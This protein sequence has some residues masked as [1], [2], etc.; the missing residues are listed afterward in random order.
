MK[1]LD[2]YNKMRTEIAS[3]EAVMEHAV[4]SEHATLTE[5]SMH[6]LKAGGKRIRPIFVLLSGKFGKGDQSRLI[7]VAA[8]LE[9]IH[10][11]SLVHDDVI[12]DA[13]TR[14]GKPTVKAKWDNRVAMYTGD[15]IF[16]KAL[17]LA[18]Q[19]PNPKIH[20]ILSRA[21]VQM[22][23]GEMEQIRLFYEPGQSIRDY[24]LRIRRKTALLI[25]VSCQI[26]A[27]AD[28]KSVV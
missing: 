12:D 28:R 11:A 2:I 16:A 25:A 19:I 22:S 26:G 17:K 1:L 23:I 7:Q 24:L 3:I 6:L 14:R 21:L 9:L 8:S 13:A 4:R 10:M 15:Y 5:A 18:S 27:L 20:Q